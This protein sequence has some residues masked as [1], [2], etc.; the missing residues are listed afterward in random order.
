MSQVDKVPEKNNVLRRNAT[1]GPQG[2]YR[3]QPL[4]MIQ[5][6]VPSAIQLARS[7]VGFQATTQKLCCRI[8]SHIIV[9]KRFSKKKKAFVQLIPNASANKNTPKN[10]GKLMVN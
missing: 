2:A 7:V 3:R 4:T 1:G 9:T 6:L 10:I 8:L 5:A